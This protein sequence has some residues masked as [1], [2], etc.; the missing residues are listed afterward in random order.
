MNYM[1]TQNLGSIL[2][3]ALALAGSGCDCG[4]VGFGDAVASTG[5]SASTTSAGTATGTTSGGETA[6]S[7]KCC[8]QLDVLFVVDQTTYPDAE[9]YEDK[10]VEALVVYP[11]EAYAALAD[12]VESYHV[13]YAYA[14][15]GVPNPRP[16]QGLGALSRGPEPN[17]LWKEGCLA[18]LQGRPFLAGEDIDGREKFTSLL[19]C[20]MSL[21]PSVPLA[22]P[23]PIEAM[24]EGSAVDNSAPGACNDGFA[25]PQ[26]P[27]LLFIL[28]S[29]DHDPE[30]EDFV[31]DDQGSD[32]DQWWHILQTR[33]GFPA[34]D[35]VAGKDRTGLIRV[36][37]LG[38]GQ[39]RGCEAK[40]TPSLDHFVHY[41]DPDNVR[42][43]ELCD[44]NDPDYAD[45]GCGTSEGAPPAAFREFLTASLQELVCSLCD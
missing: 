13:G 41:F 1:H 19:F 22:S 34:G 33:R 11:K 30:D 2:G 25:R 39:L 20:L 26:A 42:S 38:S 10:L 31:P 45:K 37:R 3:L 40:E 27:L 9:C 15:A 18:P 6:A 7:G 5:A 16:C 14:Q 23:R 4:T 43:Y 8:E 12:N 28:T 29:D 24:I 36:S 21:G 32:Q 44:L 17:D 35:V